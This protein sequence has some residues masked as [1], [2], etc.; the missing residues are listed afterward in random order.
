MKINRD[1]FEDGLCDCDLICTFLAEILET[2]WDKILNCPED[3][4]DELMALLYLSQ[5]LTRE[6]TDLMAQ[7]LATKT[8]K[9]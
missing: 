2:K 7:V 9:T 6:L 8:K 1:K 3:S 4:C 5:D